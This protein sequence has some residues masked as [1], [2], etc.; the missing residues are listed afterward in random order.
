MAKLNKVRQTYDFENVKT[1]DDKIFEEILQ[2]KPL[3]VMIN[4]GDK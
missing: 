4:V 2:I 1:C 3:S